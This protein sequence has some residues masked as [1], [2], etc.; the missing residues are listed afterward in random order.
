MR[1]SRDI[2]AIILSSFL[3]LLVSVISTVPVL[4]QTQDEGSTLQRGYRTGYSDGFMAGYKDTIDTMAKEYSRHAEYTKADRAYNQDYGSIEDYRDG[5]QQGFEAGYDT[6]FEKRA[7]DSTLPTD[8]KRRGVVAP[9]ISTDNNAGVTNTDQTST[10]AGFQSTGNAIII[11]PRDTEMVLEL[12]DDVNTK[13]T[14][15]GTKFT[16]KVAAPSEI[17]G[18][19]IEGRV[20]KITKPGRIKGRSELSLS[21]DRIVLSDSRWSNFSAM[22]TEVVAVKGDNVKRVDEEGT[23]IGQN[24][25]KRNAIKVGAPAGAG[26]IIGAVTGGPVGAAVGAGVGAAFGVGAVVVQRGKHIRLNRNQQ[27]RVRTSYETQIR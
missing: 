4:A 24:S 23:A 19:T 8:I 18:A 22:L 20:S 25:H 12:Q 11:I 3:T 7:F 2:S 13:E 21:F 5:Y 15:E 6:G 17:A 9:A 27:L 26:M 1:S 10:P 14:R 16:A